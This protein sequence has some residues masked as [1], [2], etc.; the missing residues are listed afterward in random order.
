MEYFLTLMFGLVFVV[1]LLASIQQYRK[2]RRSLRDSFAALVFRTSEGTTVGRNIQVVKE[3]LEST[4]QES[5]AV[6]TTGFFYCVGPGPSYFV[7]I[8]QIRNGW[9]I[10]YT[11]VIRPLTKERMRGALMG[12]NEALRAAFG[13]GIGDTLH[14]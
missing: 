6:V 4:G 14:A 1:A 10:N 7:A 5:G 13:D 9:R 12:D 3:V 11:W 8:A 2:A